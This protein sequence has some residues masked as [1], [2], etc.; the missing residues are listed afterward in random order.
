MNNFV[1][2]E[3]GGGTAKNYM[4]SEGGGRRIYSGCCSLFLEF[5]VLLVSAGGADSNGYGDLCSLGLL[6][7]VLELILIFMKTSMLNLSSEGGVFDGA[8]ETSKNQD[9]TLHGDG[10][11]Y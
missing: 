7:I 11:E 10:Y 8:L 6:K 5:Y 9:L 4:D 2:L 3:G 1:V